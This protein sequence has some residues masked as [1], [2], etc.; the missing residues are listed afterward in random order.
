MPTYAYI[1]PACKF[2]TEIVKPMAESQL[3]ELCPNDAFVLN[4]NYKAESG[5][6]HK[7]GNWP[8]VSTAAGVSASQRKEAIKHSHEIGIPTD[9][10]EEGDAVF[11]GRKHRK[12]YCEAIGL[13]DKDGGDGDPS[14]K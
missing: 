3:P 1:C 12:E 4:R 7:P 9:F 2:E 10:N 6:L 5:K 14:R 8:M 13:Y 11:T